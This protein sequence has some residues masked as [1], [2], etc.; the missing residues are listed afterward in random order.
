MRF[1]VTGASGFVG[2]S[3]CAELLRQGY[4]IRAAGSARRDKA[5]RVR[6]LE[7]FPGQKVTE[8]MLALYGKLLNQH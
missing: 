8:E 2:R 3:L 6:A 1:L 4:A 7:L 5:A